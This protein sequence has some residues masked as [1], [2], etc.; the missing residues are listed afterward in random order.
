MSEVLKVFLQFTISYLGVAIL[1][2]LL[3]NFLTNG[4]VWTYLR[5]KASRGRK[6]LTI[7]YSATDIYYRAGN[8]K[9]N[10]YS[11]KDRSKD[12]KYI[13]IA[14][15]EFKTFIN[16]TLGVPCIE[17]DEVGN[18]L[19][20]KDFNIV[21]LVNVDPARLNSLIMRIKNRPV[22]TTSKEVIIWFIRVLTFLGV[23]VIIFKLINIEALLNTLKT[24][25]GNI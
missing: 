1:I 21:Q 24:L 4:F 17:C 5:V 8:W 11:F 12:I 6:C 14:D 3:L 15:V 20:N 2:F 10:F 23:V 16:Y 18:K 22:E 25:S 13:P 19:V 9:E 7:V